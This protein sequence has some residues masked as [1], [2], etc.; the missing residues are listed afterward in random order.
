MRA[1]SIPLF[2]L[3]RPAAL[4]ALAIGLG[5]LAASLAP[6]RVEATPSLRIAVVDLQKVLFS[7]KVGK[8]AQEKFEASR[9]KKRR[10]LE[11]RDKELQGEEKKLVEERMDIE[12]AVAEAGSLDKI[13][14]ETK[15]RAQKFQERVKKFQ[16]EVV[17]FQKTQR[18]MVTDLAKTESDLLKPIEDQIRKEVTVV[19]QARGFDLVLSKQVA[20]YAVPAIDITDEVIKRVGGM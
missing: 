4:S 2:S 15:A 18:D 10:Q 13:G 12:K 19:A 5:L 16:D 8:A 7:T 11:A 9:K 1:I 6:A 17:Q 3:P 14:P 20:V